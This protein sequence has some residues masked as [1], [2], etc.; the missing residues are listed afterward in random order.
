MVAS[1]LA[2]PIPWLQSPCFRILTTQTSS[3]SWARKN[4]VVMTWVSTSWMNP[5]YLRPTPRTRRYW[6]FLC[7]TTSTIHPFPFPSLTNAFTELVTISWSAS[8][9]ITSAWTSTRSQ[10]DVDMS[11]SP[12]FSTSCLKTK[13]LLYVRASPS[14][15]SLLVSC[16]SAH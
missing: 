1:L 5:S 4:A 10:T 16:T 7:T 6:S 2:S 14:S 8:T 11:F 12:R 13:V 15:S 3:S 9:N